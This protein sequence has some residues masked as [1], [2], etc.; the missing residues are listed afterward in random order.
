MA[1][2]NKVLLKQLDA[3]TKKRNIVRRE[4]KHAQSQVSYERQARDDATKGDDGD[5]ATVRAE[6]RPRPWSTIFFWKTI[7]DEHEVHLQ[8]IWNLNIKQYIFLKSSEAE[9]FED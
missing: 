6:V 9:M 4:L 3:L 2:Q 8:D 7:S 5:G 1:E